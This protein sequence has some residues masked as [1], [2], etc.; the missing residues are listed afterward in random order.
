M[1]SERAEVLTDGLWIGVTG[2]LTVALS[3]GLI[4]VARGQSFFHTAAVLGSALFG[5]ATGGAVA[6]TPEIVFPY[7]G[8][9]LL[10]FLALG[11]LVAALIRQVEL[12]PVVWYLGF[13]LLLM[14]VFFSLPLVGALGA[15]GGR[16]VPWAGVP[17]LSI[18]VA[19]A[20]GAIA[21]GAYVRI[22]H[23]GLWRAMRDG[24][25]PE[26]L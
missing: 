6:V 19:N 3:V 25:D 2:Y 15:M 26:E 17:W 20:L 13:F 16:D 10:T 9:H 8:I 12:H 11:F 24:S 5:R 4:D 7:N 14:L 22:R 18:L 21:I 1:D 23:P